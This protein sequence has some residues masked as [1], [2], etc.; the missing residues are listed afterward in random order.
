[1]SRT[2]TTVLHIATDTNYAKRFQY[3]YHLDTQDIRCVFQD[4]S[5]KLGQNN[6][7]IGLELFVWALFSQSA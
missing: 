5:P 3:F 6:Q 4:Q 7:F 2:Q 1:M